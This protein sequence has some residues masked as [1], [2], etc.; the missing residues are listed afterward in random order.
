M[1][2]VKQDGSGRLYGDE[3][4]FLD[5]SRLGFQRHREQG[6]IFAQDGD[7]TG[8]AVM[9]MVAAKFDRMR[10]GQTLSQQEQGSEQDR[11][12]SYDRRARHG[13]VT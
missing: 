3:R 7:G 5:R 9:V 10:R 2:I 13:G 1:S 12:R 4:R 8:D 11:N 6:R